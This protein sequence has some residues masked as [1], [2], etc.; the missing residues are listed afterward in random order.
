MHSPAPRQRWL[1]WALLLAAPMA[2]AQSPQCGLFKADEG[3][4]TLRISSP[5]RGEQKHFGSAPSPV[6]FQQIDGKLQLVNLEYG[7]PSPLQVGDRGR[8]VEVDGTVYI[9]QAPAQCAAAATPAEG[10]CLANAVAC[11]DNRH[12]ATP[13]ALEAGC[14]EGV[15][16]MC[17]QLADRW[18]D[19]A[20][21][22]VKADPVQQKAALDAAL[23]GIKLPAACD[24]GG[25]EQETPA[26]AA[27]LES[28]PAVQA[29]LVK[30]AMTAAMTEAMVTMT[31]P[32]VPV[33]IPAERR[34]QLLRLCRE[35]AHGGF[36]E[37][38]AELSW[39][40]GDPLLAVQALAAACTPGNDTATCERLPALQAL[41]ASLRPQPATALPCGNYRAD[42]GLM[43]TLD[44]GDNGL[45][46]V[47]WNSHLRARV[48]EGDI[49]IRHDR[50]GDF[51]L[52]P[53]PGGQLLGLDT[54]TRFQVFTP[55]GDGPGRCSAP[56]QYT[57]LPLP[58]DCPQALA[59]G[60][61]EACC[62]Q[63]K[64]Q[65]CNV[66]GNRLALSGHW[67]QA[68][69]HYTT[70]CRAGVREGCENLVTAQGNDAEV[71]AHALLDRLCKADRSGLHVACDVLGT[72]NWELIDLGRALQKAADDAA[73]DDTPPP[74]HS[75]RKR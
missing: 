55:T 18:R 66:L 49:R 1:A 70:V 25:F 42:G 56:K 21:P 57:V 8:T 60:G 32:T 14:R 73:S 6:A 7:L 2:A 45:V 67:L 75:N 16:G 37:R 41:G 62:A 64:L 13:A 48:E 50:G 5:N 69:E 29:Q 15:P 11:L 23:S 47:G 4:S 22:T 59:A 46:G 74:R 26:C 33:I 51:V 43:D 31:A 34:Q 65:G 36:C 10:S 71:D 27:A 19:E 24:N 53:L 35:V 9:L 68:A 28:D 38:V 30:A 3:S 58:Q 52:R 12:E 39:D 17:L 44:F 40:A 72:Q 61:A 54:W 63:G 20:K